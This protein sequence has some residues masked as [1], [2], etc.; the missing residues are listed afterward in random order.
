VALEGN[1]ATDK[2]VVPDSPVAGDHVGEVGKILGIVK[3]TLLIPKHVV[4]EV[5]IGVIENKGAELMVMLNVD[6]TAGQPPAAAIVLVM[7]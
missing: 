4:E 5:G 3:T 2:P 6:E 7:V 1:A